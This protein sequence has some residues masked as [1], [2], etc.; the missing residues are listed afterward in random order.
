LKKKADKPEDV[1][2]TDAELKKEIETIA[3]S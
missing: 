3:G 2:I 1:T